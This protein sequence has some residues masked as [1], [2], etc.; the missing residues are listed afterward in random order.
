LRLIIFDRLPV[1]RCLPFPFAYTIVALER[2]WHDLVDRADVPDEDRRVR[3]EDGGKAWER[4][5]EVE[6]DHARRQRSGNREV[7]VEAAQLL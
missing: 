5:T 3:A 6:E 2:N 4:Y 7:A 1:S